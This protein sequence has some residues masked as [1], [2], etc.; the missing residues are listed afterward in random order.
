MH[1][2]RRERFSL[3]APSRSSWDDV[4][5][6]P[7]E[8][9]VEAID[10]GRL[11]IANRLLL[12]MKHHSAKGLRKEKIT[13]PVYG[14]LIRHATRGDHLVDAGLDVSFQRSAHGNIR[15]PLRKLFWPLQS[16]Q[17]AGQDIAS[18]LKARGVSLQGVFFTHL[19]MD[20]LSG[21]QQLPTDL[22]L[23]VGKGETHYRAW[24]LFHQDNFA[25]FDT[26]YEL[27][28]DDGQELPPL[29][30]CADV[31]GDGSFWAIQTPGHRR[32]HVS[33]LV[34]GRE[35]VVLLTGDACD[36]RLGFDLGVGPGFG[37][38]DKRRA[39][40]SLERMRAFVHSYP[41]VVVFCGHEVPGDPGPRGTAGQGE[42]GG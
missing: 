21:I 16:F 18:Q 12:N 31:F 24:P 40:Q 37:S 20:H 32:G 5:S 38:H 26:L 8:I 39:Q 6:H 29:G 15:G 2:P 42:T 27:D 19:H 33:Y 25:G 1:E 36:L 10:T 7:R 22:R 28:F 9:T 41:Q 35:R 30:R 14:H 13:V 17:R 34:N 4:L 23:V 3:P 11:H